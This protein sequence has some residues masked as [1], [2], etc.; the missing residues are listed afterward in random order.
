MAPRKR[1]TT[2]TARKQPPHERALQQL[3]AHPLFGPMVRRLSVDA[4]ENDWTDGPEGWCAVSTRG[5]VVIN[6]KKKGTVEEWVYVLA[7]GLLHLALR[8]DKLPRDVDPGDGFKQRAWR[9][10]CCLYAGKFLDELKVG[11]RPEDLPRYEMPANATEEWLFRQ[12]LSNNAIP[13]DLRCVGTR[14]AKP[15]LLPPDD[16][17]HRYYSSTDYPA[18][19]AESLAHAVTAALEVASGTRPQ[20]MTKSP[21]DAQLPSP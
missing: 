2:A 11:Q 4:G 17:P 8:H 13:E 19:F 1:K 10:A 9:T 7:H 6:A 12:F 3:S 21:F 20:W 14:G 15:D 5:F 16:N 18:L